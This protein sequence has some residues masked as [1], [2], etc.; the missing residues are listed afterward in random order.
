MIVVM[1]P[2]ATEE[3]VQAI[4]DRVEHVG[5]KTHVIVGADQTV[6]GVIGDGRSIDI[7]QIGRMTGVENVVPISKP[8]KGASR[9]FK[10]SDTIIQVGNITIGGS[11]L[12][13]MAGPC[14]VEGRTELLEIAHACQE[15]GAHIL[16][17]G[18]YKP[19]SSPYSFQ[20]LGEEGLKYLA[21]AREA[22]GMPIIT[23]VMEPALVPLVS[24]YAD[25]LQIGTRN[26]QNYALL[27]AVGKSNRPV[28]LKR[29]FSGTTEEWLMS[30]E[31]IL[32]HGNNDVMLCERGIRANETE[33]RNTFD[34]SAIPVVKHLSH[35][36]IIAD[37]SHA[38]GKWEYVGALTR[39][40]VAAGADGAIL[41]V[42]QQPDQAW[43]DGR[44]SLKPER[45][46]QLV[47]EMRAIALAVGRDVPLVKTAV[48]ANGQTQPQELLATIT[49]N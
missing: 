36:P 2:E 8:Y 28:L 29:S 17:G 20:G 42:H 31:Y 34:V 14:S 25:I 9:Q 39:A 35:L 26:M 46:A 32:S 47:T 16:R 23:E 37:T 13:V 43:S 30:A 49:A 11:D 10:P 24:E 45:F 5:C 38:A 22:T 44:Q 12:V 40:A 48:P 41:E 19:R 15:A 27:N 3:H 6:I 7:R 18:A 21:E 4:I 1:K 33:T